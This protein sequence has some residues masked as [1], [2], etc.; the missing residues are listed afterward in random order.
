MPAGQLRA[1]SLDGVHTR[2]DFGVPAP[3]YGMS[4][5]IRLGVGYNQGMKRGTAVFAGVSACQYCMG[6]DE[7]EA[8]LAGFLELAVPVSRRF[9]LDTR[10]LYGPGLENAVWGVALG[11]R[12]YVGPRRDGTTP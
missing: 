7:E 5:L 6:S 10:L 3:A 11:A 4:G 12:T 2:F 1:G 8:I 9:D